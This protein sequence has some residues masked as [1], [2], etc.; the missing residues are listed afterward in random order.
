[1]KSSYKPEYYLLTPFQT[2]ISVSLYLRKNRTDRYPT[3]RVYVARTATVG[4]TPPNN[5]W[6]VS[7]EPSSKLLKGGPMPIDLFIEVSS[8][9]EDNYERLIK[10]DFYELTKYTASQAVAA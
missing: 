3:G 8:F 7:L 9:I 1:M 10:Q 6:C 2:G 4:K 5:H